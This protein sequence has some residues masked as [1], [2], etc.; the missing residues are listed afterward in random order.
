VNIG[1]IRLKDDDVFHYGITLIWQIRCG[2][3]STFSDAEAENYTWI[4]I[5]NA[6]DCIKNTSKGYLND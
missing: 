1:V 2:F 3:I 5:V 6:T 4:Q